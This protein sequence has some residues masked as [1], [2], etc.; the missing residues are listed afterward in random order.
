MIRLLKNAIC[1]LIWLIFKI[2]LFQIVNEKLGLRQGKYSGKVGD[3]ERI[4]KKRER[5]QSKMGCQ[6]L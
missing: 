4:R 2:G 3:M 5:V 1:I 6:Q